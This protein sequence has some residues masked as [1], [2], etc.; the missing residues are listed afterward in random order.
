ML[1]TK[2]QRNK[3]RK[4]SPENN[5]PPPTGGGVTITIIFILPI[6]YAILTKYI[7]QFKGLLPEEQTLRNAGHPFDERN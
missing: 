2:K 4:K 7:N 3:E 5:T 1:L 6:K